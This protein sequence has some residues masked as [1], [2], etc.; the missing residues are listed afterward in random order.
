MGLKKLA[1]KVAEYQERLAAGHAR[2]IEPE[3]VERVLEKLRRKEADLQARLAADPE[4]AEREEFEHKLKVAREHI[5][6]AEWLK[7]ELA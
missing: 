6:R 7:R 2:K 5:E 4:D 3:H 1:A